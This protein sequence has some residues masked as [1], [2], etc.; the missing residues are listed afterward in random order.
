MTVTPPTPPP[1]LL[2]KLNGY[3]TYIVMVVG[4]AYVGSELWQHTIDVN[5][6]VDQI[7]VLLGLGA[8]RHGVSTGA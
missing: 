8:V 7:L 1:S 6:A 3:K 5:S 4:V 2:S